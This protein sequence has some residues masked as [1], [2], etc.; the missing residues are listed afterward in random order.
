[1]INQVLQAASTVQ[2]AGPRL[3]KLDEA[4]KGIEA[5]F[6]KDLL[7]AMRRGMPETSFGS[8]YGSQMYRDMFDQTLA[9][10]LGRSG[11]LGIARILYKQLSK[12]VL[13]QAAAADN[14]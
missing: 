2:E 12:Q 4:T 13:A 3:K 9:D 1:M 5:M 7:S 10:S 8:S 6:M 11:S 14:R